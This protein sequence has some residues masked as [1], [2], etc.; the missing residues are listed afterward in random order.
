MLALVVDV[1][2]WFSH[3][4][5]L[6]TKA[7]A[8]ALAAATAYG[9]RLPACETNAT[10]E[11]QISD[12]ARQYAGDP[13]SSGTQNVGV[14]DPTRL[15][16]QINSTS[17]STQATDGGG[18]CYLHP[19][20]TRPYS[21]PDADNLP[22][23]YWVD[24]KAREVNVPTFFGT[25]GITL[26]QT[27]AR[28]RVEIQEA[29]TLD[30]A[31]PFA[32]E[33]PGVTP[34]VFA[35]YYNE[36]TGNRIGSAQS[37]VADATNPLLWSSPADQAVVVPSGAGTPDVSMVVRLGNCTDS[38][39]QEAYEQDASGNF[40]DRGLVYGQA[41]DATGTVS[42]KQT[43]KVR[44]T[45]LFPSISTPCPNAY[46]QRAPAACRVSVSAN[47]DFG[48]GAAPIVRAS[49]DG[50]APVTLSLI[51]GRWIGGDFL[52]NPGSGR[53][54]ITLAWE[55]QSGTWCNNGAATC[56]GNTEKTCNAGNGNPCKGSLG[57]QQMSFAGADLYSGPVQE[58]EM[59]E[60]GLPANSFA[61][62]STKLLGA[63]V[64][65]R[66][67]QNDQSPSATPTIIRSSVQAS[68]NRSGA[69]DCGNGNFRAEIINGCSNYQI[70]VRQPL[71]TCSPALTPPDCIIAEPGNKQGQLDQG[72]TARFGCTTNQF[73]IDPSTIQAADP[74]IATVVISYFG[75]LARRN[76]NPQEEIPVIKFAW[77]YVTGWDGQSGC[78][79]NDPPPGG[80]GNTQSA[81]WGHFISFV[82]PPSGGTPS[83]RVCTNLN[84]IGACL[85]TLVD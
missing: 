44:D 77:F 65:L 5:N 35:E 16:V 79:E 29:E 75:A 59:L 51:S 70:N 17:Y 64:L 85:A 68:D 52:I 63:R 72:M 4:R 9:G 1:G 2:N 56:S 20:D 22:D 80:T 43:P 57:I 18:P 73:R 41:F 66:D 84:Q 32:V 76:G 24:V 47:V 61:A 25:F 27:T 54:E 14:N 62:G 15:N 31:L 82:G 33:S 69:L 49:M 26:P 19:D 7:D 81:I 38:D 8:G 60:G 46:F 30:K 58:A 21:P 67:L 55:R 48:G 23:G 45:S 50:G 13:T 39:R 6:Q 28:A 42:A 83:G 11:A 71:P 3:K 34:C 74:R 53:H 12:I 36:G 10:L 37:L 40:Q 78:T